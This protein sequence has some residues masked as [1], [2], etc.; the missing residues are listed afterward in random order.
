MHHDPV[1]EPV[2][3]SFFKRI[4]VILWYPACY[5]KGKPCMG[6]VCER[7]QLINGIARKPHKG[8]NLF[9]ILPWVCDNNTNY[10]PVYILYKELIPSLCDTAY[11]ILKQ[12]YDIFLCPVNGYAYC[13]KI[14]CPF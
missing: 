5:H 8:L 11:F 9:I 12:R 13:L 4:I 10:I 1:A 6:A 7:L 14:I 2:L 3:Y